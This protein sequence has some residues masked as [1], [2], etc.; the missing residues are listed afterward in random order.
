MER[1]TLSDRYKRQRA[2]SV[3]S[4]WSV[5]EHRPRWDSGALWSETERERSDDGC[6]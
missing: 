2:W 3:P 1:R 6:G 5:L 4:I